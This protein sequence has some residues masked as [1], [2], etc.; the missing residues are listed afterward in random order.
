[1]TNMDDSTGEICGSI[2]RAQTK[3]RLSNTNMTEIRAAF[4]DAL[5]GLSW[6]TGSAEV[7]GSTSIPYWKYPL[8][9]PLSNQQQA[10]RDKIHA[11]RQT[12]DTNG[13]NP[14]PYREKTRRFYAE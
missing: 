14:S 11:K 7:F 2:S 1:M 12:I 5:I 9:I 8:I 13:R 3:N 6:R 4:L 10:S